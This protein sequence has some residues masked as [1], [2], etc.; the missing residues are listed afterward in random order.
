MM[1]GKYIFFYFIFETWKITAQ[2]LGHQSDWISKIPSL[3]KMKEKTHASYIY[4][5]LLLQEQQCY[6]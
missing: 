4:I 5:F 2:S 3:I 6:L 1:S